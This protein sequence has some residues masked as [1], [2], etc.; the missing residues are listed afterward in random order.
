MEN[1]NETQ[2]TEFILLGF[3]YHPQTKVALF[4]VLL[5]IY[6]VTLI[7]NSLFII[8]TLAVS[9]LHLPMYFLLC[10]LALLDLCYS[11]V[12]GPTV[13]EGLLFQRI[14]IAYSRCMTQMYIALSLGQAEC[15]LLGVMAWD[16]YAAICKPFHY[17][18]IMNSQVCVKLTVLCWASGFL[19]SLT[20]VVILPVVHFCGHK[21]IDHTFCELQAVSRLTCT[22][23]NFSDI[24]TPFFAFVS[25]VAPLCLILFTYLRIL[26]TILRMSTADRR[27]RTFTTCGSHLLVVVL[28]YGTAMG[29]YLKPKSTLSSEVDKVSAVF[30]GQVAPALNPLIYTLRN[31]DVTV[32]FKKL[33]HPNIS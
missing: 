24:S 30:Y 19:I 28:F 9:Q 11:S 29:I 5:A 14:S 17:H 16:R 26:S 2:V 22:H 31:K 3:P 23:T 1:R 18:Q 10:N 21:D 33:G 20:S 25:L 27:H 13:L 4:V 8:I 12:S 6:L 7:A 15:F 32:A